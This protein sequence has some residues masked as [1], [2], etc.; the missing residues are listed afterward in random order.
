[1]KLAGLLFFLL[2]LMPCVAAADE[3]SSLIQSQVAYNKDGSLLTGHHKRQLD[4]DIQ[5]EVSY[6]NGKATGLG[7]FRFKDGKWVEVNFVDGKAEGKV[8]KYY[9]SGK[10]A[11]DFNYKDGLQDGE[12]KLYNEQG[13]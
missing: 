11:S 1:M 5:V 2:T 7:I 10:V 12:Q 13:Q 8:I 9:P 3:V 6:K 4:E